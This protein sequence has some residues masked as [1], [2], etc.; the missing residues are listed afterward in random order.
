MKNSIVSLFES[1]CLRFGSLV[2]INHG[3]EN[4]DYSNLNKGSNQLASLLEDLGV[5][6][7]EVVGV[8]LPSSIRLVS[9]LLAIMKAGS[10]YMPA[11]INFSEK[12]LSQ[13]LNETGTKVLITGNDEFEKLQQLIE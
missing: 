6:R 8:F 11:D 10:V 13:M 3:S 7:G 1:V 2:A 9:S 5:E 12:R 4:I